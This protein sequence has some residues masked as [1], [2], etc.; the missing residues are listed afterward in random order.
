MGSKN[1]LSKDGTFQTPMSRLMKM[2]ECMEDEGPP[3][4]K[5]EFR[6]GV[7]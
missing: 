1:Y 6:N 4:Q 5:G 2:V 7:T 3:C